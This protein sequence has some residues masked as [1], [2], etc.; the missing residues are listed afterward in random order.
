MSLTQNGIST[1]RQKGQFAYEEYEL[2]LSSTD[3]Y[4]GLSAPTRVQW[5]YRDTKGTLFSGIAKTVEQA[6]QAAEKQS[7]EKL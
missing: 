3:I 4:R 2:P 6:R 1:T 5:D 7:G